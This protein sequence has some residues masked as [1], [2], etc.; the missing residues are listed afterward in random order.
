MA[1]F[2]QQ[3]VVVVLVAVALD[4]Q[5]S[6]MRA[7]QEILQALLR[8]K[9]IMVVLLIIQTLAAVLEEALVPLLVRLVL[10]KQVQVVRV[11]LLQ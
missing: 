4:G 11:V 2:K 1:A 3:V 5:E 10:V 7:V 8:R 6:P 9:E